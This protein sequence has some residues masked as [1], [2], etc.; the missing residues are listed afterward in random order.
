MV[1]EYTGVPMLSSS[2]VQD[3]VL[4]VVDRKAKVGTRQ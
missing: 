2:A 3:I 4:V 1:D